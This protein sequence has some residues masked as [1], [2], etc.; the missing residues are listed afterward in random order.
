MPTRRQ[1]LESVA[2]TLIVSVGGS[3][4]AESRFDVEA[5]EAEAGG[6]IGAAICDG[7]GDLVAG[8]RHD[9][10]FGMC[11]TFKLPL[12]AL[13]LKAIDDGVLDAAR[14]IPITDDDI[15]PYAP[16][17]SEHVGSE[18]LTVVELA[19]A[20]Q[21]TS[22]NVAANLLLRLLGGPEAFTRSLRSLGDDVTRLDRYEPD[23]NLVAPG[24]VR[25]TTSPA[26]MARTV[27]RIVDESF[28]S[29]DRREQLET[30]MVETRTG[31]SRLRA[32]LNPD[33]RTGNKTGTGIA[34][35]MPNRTN[36]VACI[37]LRDGRRFVVSAYVEADR[38]YERFRR[39]D[40]AVVAEVGK[41]ASRAI[42]SHR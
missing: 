39:E 34:A 35:L 20:A 27:G 1:V 17:T 33:W 31:L 25:D 36:D 2:A 19:A 30:W 18:G 22:D 14:R 38:H 9:E 11:S 4:R 7:D 13:I 6:R 26:A 21:R 24:D 8:Y 41:L 40:E 10:R 28:L 12:A 42:G 29:P 37:W 3:A 32:G 23:M 16:V 15:V 5:L